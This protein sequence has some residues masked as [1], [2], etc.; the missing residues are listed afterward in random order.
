A[1]DRNG[2]GR[3][4][5]DTVPRTS[6]AGWNAPANRR[7]PVAVLIQSSQ[8]RVPQLV[9]IRYGRMMQTPF[10]FYRGAAALMAMDLARTPVTGIRVQ[11]CGDAHLMNF[12]GFATPER[13]LVFDI[14]DFDE[15]LPAP[16]EWDVKRL[17]ASV[18]VACRHNRFSKAEARDMATQCV[19]TYREH[20]RQSAGMSILDRWY[21]RLDVEGCIA[22]LRNRKEKEWMQEQIDKAI[23]RTVLHDD[24]PKLTAV[25]NG[26]VRIKDNPP[27]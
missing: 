20:M 16:W 22:T 26:E 10:N 11:A 17:A 23:S 13:H 7:D 5:R 24:F 25:K 9:P 27:L 1:N 3:A 18:V 6:H 2:V 19:R 21:S 14:N 8:G 15:T 4:L 12:G